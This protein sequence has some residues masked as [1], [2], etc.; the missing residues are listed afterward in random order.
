MPSINA[1]NAAVSGLNAASLRLNASANN[2]AN[3]F[4]AGRV[5][6]TEGS[7]QAY[8]G[9]EVRQTA[10]ESGGVRAEIVS[11]APGTLLAFDPN[12]PL[13]N[14]EGLVEVPDVDLAEEAVNQIVAEA[15]FKANAAVLRS[16]DEQTES[17]LD[18]KS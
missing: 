1:F 8:R 5:G 2:V 4:T 6:A 11:R 15:S 12:S 10:Q 18:I 3:V 7:E 17:L 9:Q 14:G 16:L 13:A